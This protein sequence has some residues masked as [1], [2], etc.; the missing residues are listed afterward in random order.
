VKQGCENLKLNLLSGELGVRDWCART[1]LCFAARMIT[2]AH[3]AVACHLF[4]AS[5]FGL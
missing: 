1:H 2:G 3:V 4:A 5:H